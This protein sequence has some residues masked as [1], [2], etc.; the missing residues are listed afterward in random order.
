MVVMVED[1]SWNR[2]LD[3][4]GAV[5]VTVYYDAVVTSLTIPVVLVHDPNQISMIP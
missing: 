4:D 5:A 1:R 2:M 3:A